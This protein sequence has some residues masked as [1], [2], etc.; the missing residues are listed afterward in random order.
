LTDI[1]ATGSERLSLQYYEWWNEA[2]HGVAHSRGIHYTTYG[3]RSYAT[4]FA[5]P[6][7]LGA[8]YDDDMVLEVASLISDEALVFGNNGIY[9][10]DFWSPNIYPFKVGEEIKR[11][12]VKIHII[13]NDMFE[14][15]LQACKVTIPIKE[16]YCMLQ[17]FCCIGYGRV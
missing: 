3:N 17:T 6:I 4:S 15:T 14:A 13:F 7:L 11:L 10:F 5:E 8:A 12:L 2:L 1:A 16:G 9:G